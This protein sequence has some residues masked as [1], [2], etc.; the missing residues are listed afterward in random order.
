M[1]ENVPEPLRA[2]RRWIC[3]KTDR[4]GKKQPHGLAGTP[5]RGWREPANWATFD[6]AEGARSEHSLDGLGFVLGDGWGGVDIDDCRDPATGDVDPKAQAVVAFCEGA[7][8]EISPSGRG[9]K[10]FGRGEGWLEVTFQKDGNVK[11]QPKSPLYFA[12]TGRPY[13]RG[14][15]VL[16]DLPYQAIATMFA[17]SATRKSEP[18]PDVVLPGTQNSTMFQEM[19]KL[20]RGGYD[21]DAITAALYALVQGGRFPAEAGRPS[22][23][24]G[25]V[26]TMA[27]RFCERYPAGS[28]DFAR[29]FTEKGDGAILN[30]P[31]NIR[32]ALTALGVVPR[33]NLFAHQCVIDRDGEQN[34]LND[35]RLN[36]LWL[37]CDERF[38]FRPSLSLFSLVLHDSAEQ[39]GFHPV[40]DYLDTLKWDGR[41]RVNM[42]LSIYAGATP[43]PYVKAVGQLFLVA[44]VRRVRQPGAK[45]DELLILESGQG[46]NKSNLVRALCPDAAWF[47]EDMSLGDDAKITIERTRGVWIAEAAEIVG[48]DRDVDRI[49]SFLSTTVDGPVRL[50]YAREPVKIPRQFVVI[51]TTNHNEYLRDLTGNRRIWPIEVNEIDLAAMEADRDQLWAEAAHLEAA[52]ESTRLDPTLWA[53]AAKEQEER[54]SP[55]G[56]EEELV[57]NLGEAPGQILARDVW[58]IL[59][60]DVEHRTYKNSK[61]LAT[62]MRYL[63][64]DRGYVRLRGRSTRVWTRG[65]SD[66]WLQ[67]PGARTLGPSPDSEV[68]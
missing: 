45:F 49:K 29:K 56:W 37:E 1:T 10:I 33:Q 68:R 47:K 18:L 57:N 53:A 26:R 38:Q 21:A 61:D 52:G 23:T 32:M 7:Y 22:W 8:A 62:V 55:T 27:T 6:D 2:E 11:V 60:V 25:D 5:L 17:Q 66:A 13:G 3:W 54:R 20:R 15:S 28:K 12:V 39:N 43:S 50:A 46:L 67:D 31:D 48:N 4:D 14:T 59:G 65:E 40:R 35:A 30:T 16:V 9:L 44:A 64:F 41:P 51:G 58:G 34:D 24:R 19:G 36:R 63:G 42:W